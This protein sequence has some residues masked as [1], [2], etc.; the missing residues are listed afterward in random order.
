MII[1]QQIIMINIIAILRD[2]CG[3][4]SSQHLQAAKMLDDSKSS[5][6][7]DHFSKQLVQVLTLTTSWTNSK[8]TKH[9]GHIMQSKD[10]AA[11]IRF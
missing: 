3:L 5:H 7:L 8:N 10:G 1:V 9:A 4:N 2:C 6:A 11:F